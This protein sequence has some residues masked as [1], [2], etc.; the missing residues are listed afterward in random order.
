M[1][2]VLLRK[3]FEPVCGATGAM[4]L[5]SQNID[6]ASSNWTNFSVGRL[7]VSYFVVPD[8]EDRFVDLPNALP[9]VVVLLNGRGIRNVVI[10]KFLRAVSRTNQC[11]LLR[12][13]VTAENAHNFCILIVD[14]TAGKTVTTLDF[15]G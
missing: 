7:P 12:P 13:V 3:N 8:A 6:T 11:N 14:R 10:Q 2:L 5:R 1:R 9:Q 15:Y 4:A